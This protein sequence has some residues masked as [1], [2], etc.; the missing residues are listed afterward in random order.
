MKKIVFNIFVIALL[1][2]S[3]L[4]II[5][6]TNSE[7]GIIDTKDQQEIQL[8]TKDFIQNEVQKLVEEFSYKELKS[9][10]TSVNI[11]KIEKDKL[12]VKVEEKRDWVYD[13]GGQGEGVREYLFTL[14]KKD[15]KFKI[16]RCLEHMGGY[17]W[18]DL[19]TLEYVDLTP[20]W[21]KEILNEGPPPELSPDKLLETQIIEKWK[22][23]N[24]YTEEEFKGIP[25]K[26]ILEKEE[27]S[28]I[29]NSY[30][31]NRTNAKNYARTYAVDPNYN[32]HYWSGNDCTNFISQAL[33]CGGWVTRWGLNYKSYKYWWYQYPLTPYSWVN[34]DY[35]RGFLQYRNRGYT[36]SYPQYLQ[37]GDIVQIDY[38]RDGRCNHSLIVTVK[39]GDSTNLI[40]VSYHTANTLDERLSDIISRNPNAWFRYRRLYTYYGD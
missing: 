26:N 30:Y 12:I 40:K 18:M 5:S 4:V 27:D 38:D 22:L 29:T 7:N 20:L 35:W 6:A 39:N 23:G 14:N 8:L 15:G 3:S 2:S 9:S 16:E 36:S 21:Y 17:F 28:V 24:D 10:I 25:E 19:K 11:E 31:Y 13:D 34:A 37:L 33:Y 32:Y 1:V